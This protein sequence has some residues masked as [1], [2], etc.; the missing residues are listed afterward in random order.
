MEIL[1][2]HFNSH[3]N[4][5][6]G[7]HQGIM[8]AVLKTFY[9]SQACE[10]FRSMCLPKIPLQAFSCVCCILLTSNSISIHIGHT[11]KAAP[12]LG[13]EGARHS[14]FMAQ[15]NDAKGQENSVLHLGTRKVGLLSAH[16]TVCVGD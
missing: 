3:R 14:S 15:S 13:H 9:A 10:A 6:H 7:L 11:C 16:Q 8:H 5:E 2:K 12:L 1:V 4:R